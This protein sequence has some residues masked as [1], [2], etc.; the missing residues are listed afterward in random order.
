MLFRSND[1][2]TTEIYTLSLHDALPILG[3]HY[4]SVP[5]ILKVLNPLFLDDL[6][7]QLVAAGDNKAK[8]LNL[9]KRI[10]R[11]RVFDPACGSGNFLVIAYKQ[12]R[13]IEAEINR[14][15]SEAHN[16][17]EIPLTN[18]RG[19]ELRD[20]PAE[21][22]RLALIIAE[23]Q[24]DVLYR[25]QQD[26][27]AEFLPLNAQNWIICHNALQLDWLSVC[28]PTGT[29]VKLVS[30]DLFNTPLDQTEIDFANEGGETYICGNPP[31]LGSTWQTDEQKADL[32]AIFASRAKN[33]KSLDY[34]AGWF[35]KAADYGSKTKAKAAFV[36]TNSICQ[37]QQVPILWPQIFATGHEIS[38]AY[39][40]GGCRS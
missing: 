34:V 5:N 1:T 2:A 30:D 14:R 23:F 37:G 17:S 16:K 20:F 13:E 33:W 18:F 11:I 15:R 9:R 8:L 3:M 26:A 6:R 27:L 39:T 25:G 12:M 21:I 10:A 35:M 36:S 29:G 40:S 32:E 19:I 4:T 22:A 28:P 24:C 38:F 7:A 31:Y